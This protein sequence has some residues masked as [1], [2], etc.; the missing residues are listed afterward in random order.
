M[1]APKV[2]NCDLDLGPLLGLC[3]KLGTHEMQSF[4]TLA[5][6]RSPKIHAA[7]CESTCSRLMRC[8][9]VGIRRLLGAMTMQAAHALIGRGMDV[10]MQLLPALVNA[11]IAGPS[12]SSG[13]TGMG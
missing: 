4:R 5:T 6:L 11:L 12:H 3:L 9:A 10:Q 13:A 2:Y 1:H 8:C 7:F